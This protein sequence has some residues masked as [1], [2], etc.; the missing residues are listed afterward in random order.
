MPFLGLVVQGEISPDAE[1][2][3]GYHDVTDTGDSGIKLLWLLP[4]LQSL[5][6]RV[7]SQANHQAAWEATAEEPRGEM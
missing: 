5:G 3:Q 6:V 1:K 7:C 4:T 2:S